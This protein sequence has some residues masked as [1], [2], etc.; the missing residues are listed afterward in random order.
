[1]GI[2]ELLL[3]LQ[4]ASGT[5][6]L[7]TA[8]GIGLL[9]LAMAS[10]RRTR[11]AGDRTREVELDRAIVEE[12]ARLAREIHDVLA[13]SLTAL[14]VQLDS[15]GGADQ[16]PQ[17]RPAGAGRGSAGVPRRRR[18]TAGRR[19]GRPVDRPALGERRRLRPGRDAGARGA[20]RRHTGGGAD[21]GRL[22]GPVA[23]AGM[24]RVL[25]V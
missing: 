10:S 7:V 2:L 18:R 11:L 16:R 13:H 17:A 22:P 5:E 12:R 25:V 8:A 20:G 4:G 3:V 9:W 6:L 15:A 19:H 21:P 24:I 23:A 1:L 14:V